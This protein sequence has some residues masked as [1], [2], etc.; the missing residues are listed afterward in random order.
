MKKLVVL[1]GHSSR[2][3]EWSEACSDYFKTWFDEVYVQK[4]THWNKDGER[5]NFESELSKLESEI[6]QTKENTEVVVFAKSVGT[7]LTFVAVGKG[8]I[9]PS[10]CV[11]FGIPLE[12]AAEG[13]FKDSWSVLEK[14]PTQTIA[15][16]NMDDPVANFEYTRDKL[17]ELN[18][19]NITLIPTEGSDHIYAPFQN[20]EKNIKSF[21]NV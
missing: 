17:I 11:L 6:Q 8:I 21:L 10:K 7:I 3:A 20:F 13:V 12:M 19:E 2:N 4:Y 9:S 15:F 5:I 18:I 16:H 14:F 1:P